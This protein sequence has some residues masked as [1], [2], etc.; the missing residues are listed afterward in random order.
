MRH[1]DL[2]RRESIRVG[3]WILTL[4]DDPDKAE[5]AWDP[6]LDGPEDEDESPF[7]DAT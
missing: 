2:G 5:M 1:E 7:E 3:P 4:T 6:D